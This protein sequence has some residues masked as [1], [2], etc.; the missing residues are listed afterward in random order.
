MEIVGYKR[1]VGYLVLLYVRLGEDRKQ[2]ITKVL[3]SLEDR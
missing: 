2:W 3:N 1:L